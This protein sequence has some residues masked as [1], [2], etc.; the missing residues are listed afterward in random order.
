MGFWLII[1]TQTIDQ[2]QLL[3]SFR[4][5]PYLI[6]SDKLQISYWKKKKEIT[7]K[8]KLINSEMVS[9][10]VAKYQNVD[11]QEILLSIKK[12]FMKTAYN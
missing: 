12:Y 6:R 8:L 4:R 11:I 10:Y 9:F 3:T 2:R 7:W 1:I 5:K